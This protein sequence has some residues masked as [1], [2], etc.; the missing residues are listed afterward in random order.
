MLTSQDI[1]KLISVLASK[2]DVRVL[3]SD[4]KDLREIILYKLATTT[5]KI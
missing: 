4:V 1:Q 2:E 5:L 3:Q